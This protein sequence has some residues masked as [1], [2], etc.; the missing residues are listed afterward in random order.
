MKHSG[1]K[2]TVTDESP[3]ADDTACAEAVRMRENT[4]PTPPWWL[5]GPYVS[6]RAWGT[7]REDYSPTGS[8]WDYFSHDLA[9]SKTYRWGED[10]LAGICDRY[11]LLVFALA[12]WNGHDPILKERA[13]GLVPSEGNHGEDVKE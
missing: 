9:R 3:F 11:Q 4:G 1:P 12:L 13:F 2:K 7:V 8:A 10:G 5:W 6:E